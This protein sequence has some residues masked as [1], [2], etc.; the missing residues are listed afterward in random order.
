MSTFDRHWQS[1]DPLP[2]LYSYKISVKGKHSNDFLYGDELNRV[3]WFPR[4]FTTMRQTEKDYTLRWYYRN[5]L[6]ASMQ[7]NSLSDFLVR[8]YNYH[9]IQSNTTLRNYAIG[10]ASILRQLEQGSGKTYRS[11]SINKLIQEN[12]QLQQ[13]LRSF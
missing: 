12:K 5:L 11:M 7:V 1:I 2:D 10:V 3:L 4:M 13:A 9:S 6:I 8:A